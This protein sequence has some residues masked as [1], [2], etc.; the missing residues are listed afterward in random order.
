MRAKSADKGLFL[1]L[2]ALVNVLRIKQTRASTPV[3]ALIG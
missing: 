3:A 1:A 2:E